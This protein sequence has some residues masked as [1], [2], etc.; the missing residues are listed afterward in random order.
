MDLDLK[1]YL[2]IIGSGT[3]LISIFCTYYIKFIE[4]KNKTEQL[5]L[6]KQHQITKE[7]YQKLFSQKIELYITLQSI[8]NDFYNGLRTI[9][10]ES[11]DFDEINGYMMYKVSGNEIIQKLF[12]SLETELENNTFIVS[13]SLYEQY[14]KISK[15]FKELQNDID[16]VKEGY[17]DED[18]HS[19]YSKNSY[20]FHKN[21]K[22]EIKNFLKLIN[23][24][25][26]EIKNQI[27]FN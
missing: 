11:Y 2:A 6:D 17:D 24:E 25:I 1:D 19:F 12:K 16:N 4:L 20:K 18:A 13:N 7:T 14:Q 22:V 8:I 5:K 15:P 3:G 27:G 26:K 9:G 21:N 23:D 10:N